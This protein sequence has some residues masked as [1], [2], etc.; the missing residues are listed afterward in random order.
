MYVSRNDLLWML[1]QIYGQRIN[2]DKLIR[3]FTN[4]GIY[5]LFPYFDDIASIYKK[6]SDRDTPLRRFCSNLARASR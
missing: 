2:Q 5:S 1:R 4:R 6:S 3:K